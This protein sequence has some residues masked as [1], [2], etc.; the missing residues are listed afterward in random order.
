MKHSAILALLL[1]GLFWSI[2]SHA[3]S[4]TLSHSDAMLVYK[5][6]TFTRVSH[7]VI[8]YLGMIL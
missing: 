4:N 3:D 5:S 7:N 8:V 6:P 1:S 2:S